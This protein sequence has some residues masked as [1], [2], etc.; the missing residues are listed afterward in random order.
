MVRV[1]PRVEPLDDHV[2]L[3]PSSDEEETASGIILP[4][5]T[6]SAVRS[7]VVLAI[8]HGVQ[9]IEPGDRV[10]YR[11]ERAVDVQL[12]PDAIVLVPREDVVARYAD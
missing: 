3:I 9:G 2:T 5:T 8:G 12:P 4:G 1:E 6:R 10:L 11:H 7:A